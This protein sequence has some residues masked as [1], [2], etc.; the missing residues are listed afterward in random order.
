VDVEGYVAVDTNRYSV[1]ERLVGKDVEIHKLWDRV[2]VFFK[3]Q[4]VAHHP[5]LLD[6]R[7][8]KITGKGHHAALHRRKA[9][10]GPSAEEKVLVGHHEWLDE[11][12]KEMKKRAAGRGTRSLRRLLDL[13]RTYPPEAFEKALGEALRYGLYDLARVEELIL[14]HVAGDFFTIEDES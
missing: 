2:E 3:N 6:K 14:S 12:V 5:R 7:E 9:Y 4:K 8:T 13:K 1:P 10:E 11:F